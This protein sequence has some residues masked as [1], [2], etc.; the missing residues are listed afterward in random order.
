MGCDCVDSRRRTHSLYAQ[1]PIGPALAGRQF[2]KTA[3]C[4]ERSDSLAQMYPMAELD[5][6]RYLAVKKYPTAT[7]KA[8]TDYVRR[9]LALESH[10]AT[11]KELSP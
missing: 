10:F 11:L 3:T 4:I 5:I 8:F 2:T 7:F 1:L 9:R 6:Q